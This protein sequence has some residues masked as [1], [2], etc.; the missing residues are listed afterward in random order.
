[1]LRASQ[2][3]Q[4]RNHIGRGGHRRDLVAEPSGDLALRRIIE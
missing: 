3:D 2:L 4:R 1:M